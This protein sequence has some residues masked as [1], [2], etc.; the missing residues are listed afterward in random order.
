MEGGKHL[1]QMV[2]AQL[3]DGMK[4]T[5]DR[6]LGITVHIT[7]WIKDPNIINTATPN[8]LKERVGVTLEITG[9]GDCCLNSTQV[10]QTL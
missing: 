3:D 6:H 4:R 10:P 2:L 7:Q 5:A 9:T 8:L 1:Q